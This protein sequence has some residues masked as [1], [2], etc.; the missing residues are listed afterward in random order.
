MPVAEP[1]YVKPGIYRH[2]K[3]NEYQ[4]FF[5]AKHS[6]TLEN[7]VVYQCLYGDYSHWI[8]PLAMFCE[9]VEM[10]EGYQIPRFQFVRDAE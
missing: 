4:V 7:L 9:T 8:R 10:D 2:Y 6:E 1:S 5:A 3:G